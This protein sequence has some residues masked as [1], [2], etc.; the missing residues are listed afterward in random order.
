MCVKGRV[1]MCEDTSPLTHIYIT[2]HFSSVV[3]ELQLKI[4]GLNLFYGLEHPLLVS[5]VYVCLR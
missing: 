3:H 2:V 1:Y 4:A 5:N